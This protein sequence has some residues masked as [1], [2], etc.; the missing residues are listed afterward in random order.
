MKKQIK[1]SIVITYIDLSNYV[2]DLIETIKTKYS[3]HIYLIDNNSTE[4][5]KNKLKHF[6]DSSCITIIENQSN[7]GCASSWNQGIVRAKSDFNV[8]YVAILNNDIL[9]HPDCLDN[10]IKVIEENQIPLVSGFDVCKECVTP[11]DVLK[12]PIPNNLFVVDAPQFSCYTVSVKLLE[13]LRDLDH[14]H[15]EYF[16]LF[17]QK[18]YPA[19]FEDNDFHYRIK[20]AKMRCVCTNSALY[21]HYGSRTVKEHEEVGNVNKHYFLQNK[22]RYAEKWGGKP[23]SE[24]YKTPFNE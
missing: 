9:L 19:Y 22:Q 15:E 4:E 12:L 13:K 3:Y 2:I 18:F 1:L 11:L 14:R 8:E 10:M 20:L 17:D 7:I 5:T 21:Y 24:K 23:G 6:K 16:G